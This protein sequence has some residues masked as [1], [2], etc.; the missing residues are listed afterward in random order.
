MQDVCEEFFANCVA[1]ASKLCAFPSVIGD[2]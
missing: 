1:L 2:L